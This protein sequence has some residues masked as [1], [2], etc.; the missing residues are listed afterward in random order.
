MEKI[1]LVLSGVTVSSMTKYTIDIEGVP[2]GWEPVRY[3]RSQTGDHYLNELGE[4]FVDNGPHYHGIILRKKTRRYDWSKVDGDVLFVAKGG[5]IWRYD[6]IDRADIHSF[7]DGW[8]VNPG[9]CP[10]DPDGTIVE[11]EFAEGRSETRGA[12]DFNFAKEGRPTRS[13][14]TQ[15]RFIRFAEGIEV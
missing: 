13:I 4:H 14:I 12:G 9:V 3:D 15:W 10:V 1:A 8:Q 5:G 7:E 11:V 2:E 6:D